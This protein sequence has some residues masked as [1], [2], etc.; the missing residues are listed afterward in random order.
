MDGKRNEESARQEVEDFDPSLRL[1]D[2]DHYSVFTVKDLKTELKRRNLTVKGLKADL[3]E[4]LQESDRSA[5]LTDQNSGANRDT[6]S[7]TPNG[8]NTFDHHHH[9]KSTQQQ[10][11]MER[12]ERQKIVLWRKPLITLQYFFLELVLTFKEYW[13]RILKHRKSCT[14]VVVTLTTLSLF[15]F[16]PGE[17]QKQVQDVEEFLLWCFYWIGLGILSSV[18]LGTGLHTFLLY[19]GPHIAQVTLAAWECQSLD[20]PEPP[21]PKEILCPENGQTSTVGLLTIMSKVR[22]EAFMWGA[23]TA[24][25]ELP[26]YFM[27]KAARLSGVD[28]DDE[29]LEEVE[30]LEEL[31]SAKELD[32]W[33]RTKKGIF[34]FV[35]RMGFFG[36]LVCASIPNPLFDLAGITCGHCLI[37]FWTFF[38]ATL[39]GKAI[40]KMHLQKTF[41]ILSFS[42]TYV[43]TVLQLAG[44]IPVI[45]PYIQSP[46]KKALAAQRNSLHRKPG[47]T[48]VKKPSAL[49]WIFEKVV[50]LMVA[51]FLLSIINSM[52]QAYDKRLQ[53]E[54]RQAAPRSVVK[55]Q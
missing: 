46:F 7:Y 48:L 24:I 30:K 44:D 31:E 27:A 10:R 5:V 41:V 53:E 23:G 9:H 38:G 14:F 11:N 8:G 1:N 2:D 25:G 18:G 54:K 50:L 3:I 20:F 26:P 40:I 39:I 51:Y 34:D 52:A 12:E 15:Y 21:Y 36:I 55:T 22:L 35:K 29:D 45:G 17:H 42:K 37:P 19:L 33:T 4:R 49:A 28:L 16:V 43:E 47:E 6:H 32:L 13:K